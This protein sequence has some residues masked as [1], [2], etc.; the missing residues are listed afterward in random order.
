MRKPPIQ[1]PFWQTKTLDQMSKVEWE[2]LCDGCGKCCL[3]KLEDEEDGQVYYTNIACKYLNVDTCKCNDYSRRLKNVPGCLSLTPQ[4]ASLL[5]WLPST[6][7]YKLLAN[8]EPLPA[9]HPLVAGKKTKMIKKG[10]SVAG[11]VLS[12]LQVAE[13]DYQEHVVHWVS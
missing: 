10:V 5:S 9:W 4:T 6:C 3:H 7:A 2:Q 13:E 11:K 12:E 1:P 8:N